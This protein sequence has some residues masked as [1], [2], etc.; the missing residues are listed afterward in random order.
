MAV[1][2]TKIYQKMKSKNWLGKKK[3]EWGRKREKNALL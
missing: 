2:D 1:K 3:I